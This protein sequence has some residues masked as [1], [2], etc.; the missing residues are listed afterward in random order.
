MNV[1]NKEGAYADNVNLLKETAY[2]AKNLDRYA[3]KY[4]KIRK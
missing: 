1:M 3:N 4:G 2:S